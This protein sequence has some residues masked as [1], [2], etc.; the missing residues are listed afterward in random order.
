MTLIRESSI[1]L[2][3]ANR[4]SPVTIALQFSNLMGL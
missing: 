3:A 1:Y 2:E 4:G